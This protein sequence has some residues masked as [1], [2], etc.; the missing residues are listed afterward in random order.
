MMFWKDTIFPIFLLSLESCTYSEYTDSELRLVLN[1][2]AIRAI[3][4]FKFPKVA[5]NYNVDVMG[6]YYFEGDGITDNEIDVIVTW[7]E[8]YWLSYQLS[9]EEHFDNPTYDKSVTAF[10]NSG[11]I[12]AITKAMNEKKVAAK[13]RESDYGRVTIDRKP[14]IGEVNED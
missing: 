12:N 3:S 2:F 1:V 6:D 7:M 13:S 14:A 10:A 9:K 8:Y 4:R 5:L 11:I